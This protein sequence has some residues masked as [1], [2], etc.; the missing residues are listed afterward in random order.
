MAVRDDQIVKFTSYTPEASAAVHAA[1]LA[2]QLEVFEL[3]M[4]PEAVTQ[5][6]K[7]TGTNARSIDTV[8]NDGP[9]GPESSLFTQSGYGGYLE[10]GTA[11]MKAQPYIYPAFELFWKKIPSVVRRI[12]NG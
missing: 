12:L 3:D 6:P 1:I 7:K 4:K 10:L 8:T 11:K 2:A 5:S 9:K